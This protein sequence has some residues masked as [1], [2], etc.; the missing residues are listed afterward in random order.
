MRVLVIDDEPGIRRVIGRA[1]EAH[2]ITADLADGAESALRLLRSQTYALVLLDVALPGVSGD[3]LLREVLEAVPGQRVVMISAIG[4]VRTKVFF[5]DRGAVDY[6]AKPFALAELVSRVRVHARVL[7]PAAP[8]VPAPVAP[9]LIPA[10]REPPVTE[11]IPETGD[12]WVHTPLAALDV[13]SRR[14][15]FRGEVISLS[16]RE[17]RLLAV[18]M[19]NPQPV[20]ARRELLSAV[21]GETN[22]HTGNVVDV[23][24]G[25]LRA[26]LPP[27]SI[28]TVRNEGYAFVG[29]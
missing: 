24:V 13:D 10:R 1:L 28:T 26:K 5:L 20:C 25:R 27:G 17:C 22:A 21:W 9:Q 16:E 3:E 18:L 2:R 7:A 6:V 12:R 23:Y 8:D 4:D 19:R 29:A 15:H 11:T 14:L